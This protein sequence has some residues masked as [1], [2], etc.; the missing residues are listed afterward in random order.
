MRLINRQVN[1]TLI[2]SCLLS[3]YLSAFSAVAITKI[4]KLNKQYEFNIPVQSLSQ[5]L[6]KLS[7][8]A[9]M[10]FLF[11]YDLVENK[12]GNSVQ[13]RYT[14]RFIDALQSHTEG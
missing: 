6:N 12:A 4:D 8:V 10:S 14:H 1:K 9:K 13:G 11:P 2:V 3:V 5:S 7:D